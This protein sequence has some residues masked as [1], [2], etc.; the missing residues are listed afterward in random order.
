[1]GSSTWPRARSV[2]HYL[3][4]PMCLLAGDMPPNRGRKCYPRL[5]SKSNVS[6]CT[7]PFLRSTQQVIQ[8]Q[9]A[10]AAEEGSEPVYVH[11]WLKDL[12]TGLIK[13]LL[14][15]QGPDKA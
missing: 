1:M 15:S 2:P 4:P 13:D 12:S 10:K 7:I 14:C 8:K 6:Y 11:G 5:I 3:S 9:W